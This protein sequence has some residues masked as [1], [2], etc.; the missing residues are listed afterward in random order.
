MALN[1][2]ALSV[3][4]DQ[5]SAG[6][7]KAIVL[8][9][10]TIKRNLV[11]INFGVK[12]A[13]YQLNVLSFNP[14]G[15]SNDGCSTFSNSGTTTFAAPLITMC[16]IKF[17]D[18]VC[19]NDLHKYYTAWEMATTMNNQDLGP[20]EE[21]FMT[22]HS[23]ATSREIGNMFW[24]GAS[25]TPKYVAGLAGNNLLCDGLIQYG[26]SKSASTNNITATAITV[27]NA[28][29]VVDAIVGNVTTNTPE[30]LEDFQINLSPADFQNYLF[31]L[32][33]LNL[34]Q[35]TTESKNVNEIYHPGAIGAK[36]VKVNDMKGVAS[37]T[38]LASFHDNLQ[39]SISDE[40]DLTYETW[41]DKPTDAYNF[42]MKLRTG[43]G[44]FQPELVTRSA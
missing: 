42:R 33:N 12:G 38:F 30:I 32:R 36:I 23:E 22:T 21:V 39:I 24:R 20:F 27:A 16:P 19:I 29:V 35:Y 26:Y 25:S 10:D 4:T 5:I 9:A 37:G 44:F 34:F 13:V 41:F 3:Y 2:A 43:V 17:E 14:V 7:A 18:L 31:S 6:L 28:Y 15:K 1:L 11:K 40:A 8:E